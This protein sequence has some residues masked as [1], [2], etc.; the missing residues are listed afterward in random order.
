MTRRRRFVV[1]CLDLGGLRALSADSSSRKG[2]GEQKQ[3]PGEGK[4]FLTAFLSHLPMH[5][6]GLHLMHT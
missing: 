4:L 6:S 3:R 2:H 1:L 5:P